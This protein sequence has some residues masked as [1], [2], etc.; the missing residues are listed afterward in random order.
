MTGRVRVTAGPHD[1][2][3]TWKERPFQLQDV[4]EPSKRDS[5]EVHMVAGM[6]KL[7]TVSIDGPYNVRGVSEGPSRQA[8][9]CVP[10]RRMTSDE[11]ARRKILTNLARRAY[12]RP[13]TPADVEAPM[14][15]YKQTRQN[16][17]NFDDGIR[18]GVARVLS[19]PYFLYRIEKDPADARPPARRIR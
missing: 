5:Q 12:R 6:P 8:A 14:S 18:A 10:S 7:R 9:L 3:F 16:G 4:W 19:S 17:G 13:V 2:G 1:V 15:F 11:T